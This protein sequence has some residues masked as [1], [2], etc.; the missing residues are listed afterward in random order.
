MIIQTFVCRGGG[1]QYPREYVYLYIKYIYIHINICVCDYCYIGNAM[2]PIVCF[3]AKIIKGEPSGGEVRCERAYAHGENIC[4]GF[5][6]EGEE[7]KGPILI[8]M[9]TIHCPVARSSSSDRT[10]DTRVTNIR[11]ENE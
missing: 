4:S 8:V 5:N 7:E 11:R 9:R 2:T 10:I 3:W 1:I 6:G